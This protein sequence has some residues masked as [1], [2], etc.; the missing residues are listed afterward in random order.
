MYSL[1]LE[2]A[3]KVYTGT[4]HGSPREVARRLLGDDLAKGFLAKERD[5]TTA[6][7]YLVEPREVPEGTPDYARLV[8]HEAGRWDLGELR[9]A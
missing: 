9:G 1:V 8:Y 4:G 6:I 2:N 7:L 3:G 5:D